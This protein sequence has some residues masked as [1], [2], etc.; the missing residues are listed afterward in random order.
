[1]LDII[2]LP[3]PSFELDLQLPGSGSQTSSQ[4][5][6]ELSFDDDGNLVPISPMNNTTTS[7]TSTNNNIA[8][9]LRTFLLGGSSALVASPCA[10]PVLT[11]ILAYVT[12]SRNP[13][14]GAA[15]LFSYTAG[16][17]TLLLV[18]GATGG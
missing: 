8:S 17:S 2:N 10:T 3:L 6:S 11:S 5:S 15:L 12:A 14:L 13:A 4:I 7:T 16:Y 1:M 18:I 9:L